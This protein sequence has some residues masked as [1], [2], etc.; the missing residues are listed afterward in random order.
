MNQEI[1]GRGR[2]GYAASNERD[3]VEGLVTLLENAKL[4]TQMGNIGRNLVLNYYSMEALIPELS[5]CIKQ[6]AR[7]S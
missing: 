6:T 4:R 3:W 5:A 7:A 2:C 1:L